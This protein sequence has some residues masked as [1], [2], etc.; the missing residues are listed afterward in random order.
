[1]SVGM[2]TGAMKEKMV[3][4]QR[5]YLDYNATA[6]VLPAVRQAVLDQ[7]QMTGNASSIHAEG[8]MAK[9]AREAARHQIA[10]W[11]DSPAETV[12]F[13][14][15]G[16]EANDLALNGSAARRVLVGATEHD[17]VLAARSDAEIIPV[18]D[19]GLI[20]LDRLTEMLGD[21]GRHILVS[22]MLANNETG[23]VQPIGDIVEIVHK[24]GGLVHCDAV[25]A[26]GKIP[27]SVRELGL[28]YATVS[29]HKIGGPQGIGALIADIASPLNPRHRGGGQEKFRRGG[30]EN[31]PGIVGFGA[32]AEYWQKPENIEI[33]TQWQAWR[34]RVIA[35][36]TEV[37]PQASHIPANMPALPNTFSLYMPGVSAQMQ[38]MHFDLA[39]ISVSAGSACSSGKTKPSH[40]LRAMGLSEKI[41]DQTIRV[42]FGWQTTEEHLMYFVKHWQ[43]L[44]TKFA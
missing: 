24:R 44:Y 35:L 27:F 20:D 16:T 29:A 31:M 19:N 4:K 6:P 15:G 14:S 26:L 25:Q 3:P 7:L 9:M 2:E 32:L 10:N 12:I 39:G 36:L 41:C 38:I 11:I 42:S 23:I 43:D 34:H 33:V 40:V 30:T 1:M 37:C 5:F 8:R 28:D 17:A 13:T 22:V 21:D 18:D